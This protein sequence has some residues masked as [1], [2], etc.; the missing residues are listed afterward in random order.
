MKQGTKALCLFGLGLGATFGC[1]PRSFNEKGAIKNTAA[2]ATTGRGATKNGFL[3]DPNDSSCGGFP[4]LHIEMMDKTCMGLVHAG[5]VGSFTPRVIFPIPGKPNQFL[6][7]DFANWSTTAGK[8]WHMTVDERNPKKSAKMVVILDGLSAPHQIVLGPDNW[9]FFSED[10]AIHRV[11]PADVEKAAQTGT[12]LTFQAS[13]PQGQIRTVLSGLPPMYHGQN[14]NSMHPLKHFVFDKQWN[15]Y[16]NL[17]AY[18]DHC[19]TIASK[20]AAENGCNEVDIKPDRA[21]NPPVT[22]D[23]DPRL[24]GA[25][26]RRYPFKGSVAQGWDAKAYTIVAQGLRNSMGLLFAKNGDLLQA[27]NGRDFKESTRPYEE[28][29]LIPSAELT[30]SK[31]L[32]Y[33]WP[34]CYDYDSAAEDWTAA[35]FSCRPGGSNKYTPP[36]AFLPPHSAPLGLAYYEANSGPSAIKA[37]EGK[38]LVSLHGYRPA[39]HRVLIYNVDAKGL[40]VRPN[41]PGASFSEDTSNGVTSTPYKATPPAVPPLGELVKGWYESPGLRPKGAPVMLAQAADGSLYMTDDKNGVILRVAAFQGTPFAV[42]GKPDYA[43]A[44]TDIIKEAPDLKTKYDALVK[45]VLNSKQCE[46]CHDTYVDAK[47][48]KEDGFKQLRYVLAMG[49]WVNLEADPG[50]RAGLSTLYTKL[51][52]GGSMPPLD[53]E[54]WPGNDP[55]PVLKAIAGFIDA[56]PSPKQVWRA[57]LAANITGSTPNVPGNGACGSVPAGTFVVAKQTAQLNGM[58]QIEMLVGADTSLIKDP[59][60]KTKYKAFWVPAASFEKLTK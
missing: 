21:L 38:L 40:P 60:C 47:D 13:N 55:A 11:S 37:L 7:S 27:E 14:K 44:Y 52:P 43:S 3:H 10:D 46:G 29:N 39:G 31:P 15:M 35:N 16:I 24:H 33:G 6:I 12:K 58:P 1:K 2:G 26:I 34:Y 17:G 23:A 41:T 20:P 8:L 9:I 28:L 45:T 30:S 56:F 42:A 19:D 48:T 50:K 18:T 25:V 54:P 51:Q 32:H 22:S 5:I 59:A 36:L 53:R 49:S 4:R 57:K